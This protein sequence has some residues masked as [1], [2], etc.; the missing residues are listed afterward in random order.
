MQGKPQTLHKAF[1]ILGCRFTGQIGQS[2]D[3]HAGADNTNGEF[4]EAIREIKRRDG[5]LTRQR[6]SPKGCKK[7]ELQ[8]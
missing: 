2:R 4:E 7:A 1:P 5:A 3:A 8:G 6:R